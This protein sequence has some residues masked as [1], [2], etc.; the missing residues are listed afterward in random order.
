MLSEEEIRHVARI[1]R[2]ELRDEEIK[3]FVHQFREIFEL[4]ERVKE[5]PLADEA[6]MVATENRSEFREDKTSPF[7]SDE[8]LRNVPKPRNRYVV[9]PK[10]L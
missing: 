9:V 7:P 10:N 6:P 3:E 1:A 4:L 8:I 5:I 2:V